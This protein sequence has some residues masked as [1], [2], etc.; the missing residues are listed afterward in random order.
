MEKVGSRQW[1]LSLPRSH[2]LR[3][4][5]SS[6]APRPLGRAGSDGAVRRSSVGTRNLSS[7]ISHRSSWIDA[8]RRQELRRI[9]APQV[10]QLSPQ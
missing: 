2:A 3:G 7:L 8:A 9:P 4:N 10:S 5:G 1:I 6:A